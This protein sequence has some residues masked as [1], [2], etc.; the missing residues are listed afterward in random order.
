M[1]QSA[2]CTA[3]HVLHT[4]RLVL[5]GSCQAARGHQAALRSPWRGHSARSV[6][7]VRAHARDVD[8]CVVCHCKRLLMGGNVVS[9]SMAGV[10]SG[11]PR[12]AFVRARALQGCGILHAQN[13][14]QL[15]SVV[16]SLP[17]GGIGVRGSSAPHIP[18]AY[19]LTFAS[20]ASN[21]PRDRRCA[22]SD[23][24]SAHNS[25]PVLN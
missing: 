19:S 14:R 3:T 23:P 15:R 11:Q 21:N 12:R 10:M 16:M 2:D 24:G 18:E 25:H 1:P 20:G 13:R 22:S 8:V 6:K 4:L 9:E 17:W 7:A 5:C